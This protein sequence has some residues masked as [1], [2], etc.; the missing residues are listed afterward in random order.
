[1]KKR[2]VYLDNAAATPMSDAVIVAMQPHFSQ[3]FYNPSALYEGARSAK[4]ALEDARSTVAQTIGC[5]PSEIVFTAGGTE[6]AN[7]AIHGVG[8]TH[9]DKHIII[10][11]VE[12]EAVR[13]PAEQYQ[14][15]ECGVDARGTVDISMLKTMITDDTVLLSVMYA[16]NEVGTVQPIK[17]VVHIA[18]EMRK[19]RAKSGNKTPLYVHTDAC[20]APLY[21]DI[22]VA[23]L[24]VDLMTLNGSKI[25]GPKQ[26]GVLYVRAGVVLE[27][28]VRGGGQE[29]GL[30]SGTENV[31]GAVGFAT[32]LREAA[33]A[34]AD[35]VAHTQQLSQ[36]FINK[37]QERFGAEL[38]GHKR[39][40]LPNNVHAT[41]PGCDNERVL[42]ALDERGV[43]A[44]SGSACSASNG[45]V[46]HVLSAMGLDEAASRASLRFSLGVD[47][48]EQDIRYTL[49]A[50][51]HALKA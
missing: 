19:E 29:H 8:Q 20:Q 10:S 49:E 4:R 5:R 47:T 9:P 41:F 16:N 23:R 33:A 39:Q 11:A 12:H 45:E 48:T 14:A 43:M 34:R 51:S 13:E 32:A 28:L 46:S 36:Q 15:D 50:L 22:N 25:H 3:Q 30:R 37:L 1:M 35:N 17:E 18:H 21:L 7:L 40:R 38:N 6:S 2:L 42:F 24:G 44:A 31:A 26:T 27:P